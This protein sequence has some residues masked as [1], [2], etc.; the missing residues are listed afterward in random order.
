[1]YSTSRGDMYL[2]WENEAVL[3][4]RE[5]PGEYELVVPSIGILA[6]W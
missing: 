2:A 4:M 5:H 6:G 1:M 3:A